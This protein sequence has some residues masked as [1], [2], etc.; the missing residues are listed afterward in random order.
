MNLLS[1]CI[2]EQKATVH[3]LPSCSSIIVNILV[4]CD[5]SLIIFTH[6]V[7]VNSWLDSINTVPAPCHTPRSLQTCRLRCRYQT[8]ALIGH[9]ADDSASKEACDCRHFE[10]FLLSWFPATVPLTLSLAQS[11]TSSG[12]VLV[13]LQ[14]CTTLRQKSCQSVKPLSNPFLL[15]CAIAMYQ[16]LFLDQYLYSLNIYDSK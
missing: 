12:P 14:V 16:H 3:T 5:D 9:R 10:Q 11:I 4:A 8:T 1:T 13:F 7:V 6:L 15:Y 2:K